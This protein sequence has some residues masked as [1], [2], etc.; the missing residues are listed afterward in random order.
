MTELFRSGTFALTILQAMKCDGEKWVRG[1][2]TTDVGFATLSLRNRNL[3][4]ACGVFWIIYWF[5][6]S[7]RIGEFRSNNLNDE[8]TKG[9]YI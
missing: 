8:D 5:K 1:I 2:Y 9:E 6:W 3:N 4:C 7:T